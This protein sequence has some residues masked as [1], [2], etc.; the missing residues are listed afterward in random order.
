MPTYTANAKFAVPI[1]GESSYPATLMGDWATLDG[2]NAIGDLTVTFKE[3]PSA[4]LNVAV[5]SGLFRNSWGSVVT[6]A[7]TASQTLTASTS[8]YI[9][10]TNS[11]TL[12]VSTSAFPTGGVFYVPLAVVVVGT[13]AVTSIADAR[14]PFMAVAVQSQPTMGAATAG[15]TYTS[16]EQAMLQAVFNAVRALG[17]GT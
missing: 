4:S 11:G 14:I 2:V 6:Y 9:Y 12:T 7:G 15:A 3:I 8:N 5:S 10:L 1:I 16:A 17:L 13:S